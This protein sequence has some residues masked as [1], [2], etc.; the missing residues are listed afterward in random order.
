LECESILVQRRNCNNARAAVIG[1]S[2][3]RDQDCCRVCAE[4]VHSA[5]ELDGE[6]FSEAKKNEAKIVQ[7]SGEYKCRPEIKLLEYDERFAVFKEFV[8][9]DFE[10]AIQLPP[11]MKA[12]F[13]HIICDPPFLSEDCQTKGRHE[14]L[15]KIQL[16]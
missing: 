3:G 14:L 8:Y 10:K 1:W 6:S 12:S 16:C 9:Y 13:D 4:C 5:E 15:R 7:A 2:Y 11:E